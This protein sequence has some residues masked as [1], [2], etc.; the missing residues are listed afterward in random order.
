MHQR[1]TIRYPRKKIQPTL[2]N[3][4]GWAAGA[5]GAKFSAE[6][7]MP[8]TIST[9]THHSTPSKAYRIKRGISDVR[10]YR[11]GKYTMNASNI[12]PFNFISISKLAKPPG[13]ALEP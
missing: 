8:N 11:A 3:S 10:A 12:K 9:I 7:P 5:T 1:N 2:S 6:T 4:S 13:R